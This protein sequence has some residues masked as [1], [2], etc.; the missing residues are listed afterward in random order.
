MLYVYAT[1]FRSRGAL[2]RSWR[3]KIQTLASPKKSGTS[4]AA[5]QTAFGGKNGGAGTVL[6]VSGHHFMTVNN[7]INH[8]IIKEACV[9]YGEKWKLKW[10]KTTLKF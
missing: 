9:T 7:L 10:S 3:R 5:V 4:T 1:F 8:T 6:E 2:R